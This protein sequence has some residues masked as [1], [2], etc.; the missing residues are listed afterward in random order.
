VD[1]LEAQHSPCQFRDTFSGEAIAEF[2][3]ADLHF[4]LVEP[5]G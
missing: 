3:S 2:E 1:K 5:L 4:Q